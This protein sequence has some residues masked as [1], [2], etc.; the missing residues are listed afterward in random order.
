MQSLQDFMDRLKTLPWKRIGLITLCA[1]L[2]IILIVLIFVTAYAEH[3]LGQIDRP[4][5]TS[6]ST[7]SPEDLATF[8]TDDGTV[9]S[10]YSGPIYNPSDVTTP[11]DAGTIIAHKDL[12]NIML[13][14]QDRRPGENYRTR[15]DAMI[16]CT[17]NKKDKT[18]TMTSFLRD[19]YVYIPGY[20]SD[21]MN[22]AYQWGGMS[23][24]RETMMYNFGIQVDA[25]V[26][27]DFSG[28]QKVVDVVGGVDINL[29]QAEADHLNKT[30][31]WSL[32]AG[33]NRLNGEEALNYS[34][35]RAIGTDFGRTDRQRKVV[36]SLINSCKN[37]SVTQALNLVNEILPLIST[38]MSNSEIVQYVMDLFPMLAGA[39]ISNL[40][41]PADGTYTNAYVGSLDVL[42]PDMDAN[43]KILIEALMP[44]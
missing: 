16:L 1:V 9:P 32:K 36:S 44:N 8:F 23:L 30:Y 38:D 26:E 10:D 34:R 31:K 24:L 37:M 11:T 21:K 14:G 2:A 35:I 27:V 6:H 33:P 18:L 20:R 43:R 25:F 40:R 15:S 39:S 17:F 41:I 19:L 12:V 28:F 13:V 29:T 7:L 42:L 3:L 4:D 5:N 22:A